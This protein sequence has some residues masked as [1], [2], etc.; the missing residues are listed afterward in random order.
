MAGRLLSFSNYI[1]SAN[2]VQVIEMFPST[3][4]TF[5]YDYGVNVSAYTFEAD[6]QTIVVDTLTYDRTTGD[7]N[8][9]DSTVVGYFA[10]S[11]IGNANI[12]TTGA[13][14]GEISL[15]IPKN[16]YTGP[17]T[18]DARANVA[19]TVVGFKWTDTSVTPNTTDSHRWAIIER[20]EPDVSPGNP[21]LSNTFIQLGVG[22]ISNFSDNSSTDG[23]RT[24]GNYTN[25][26]GIVTGGSQGDGAQFN[27]LVAA[28][29]RCNIDITNRGTAYHIGDT[30]TILDKDLGGGG[31]ADVTITV[32]ATA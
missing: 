26:T 28:D 25:V 15:T 27:V 17:I 1:G 10:N 2:N 29:G 8:F 7:P 20:Y 18:P 30:I 32:S 14:S 13:A 21:R 24:A 31:G 12:V 19:I 22:A 11:E 16:R 4:K 3:Q 23:N 6:M 5:T 9:T